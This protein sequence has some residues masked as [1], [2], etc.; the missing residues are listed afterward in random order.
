[1]RMTFSSEKVARAA[2]AI[3]EQYGYTA[4]PVGTA[5]VTDCPTLLAVPVV[6]RAIGLHEVENVHL[7]D[8]ATF[9]V[10]PPP[11]SAAA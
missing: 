11:V 4:E 10:D 3:L 1:M 7:G 5:I 2:A 9:R 8:P 6:G